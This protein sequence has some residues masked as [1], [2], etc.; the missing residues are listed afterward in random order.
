ML[1]I[2]FRGKN[3]MTLLLP[4]E[5]MTATDVAKQLNM[6]D[7]NRCLSSS[8]YVLATLSMPKFKCETEI[9]ITD[10]LTLLGLPD[11]M[12]LTKMG[13]NS[14]I[15]P[16]VKQKNVTQIDEEGA[17]VANVTGV[18][19]DSSTYLLITEKI[20]ISF[21]RPFVFFIHNYKTGTILISGIINNL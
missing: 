18:S 8:E 2:P 16:I 14:Y 1:S 4:N 5:E 17:V 9:D 6:Q 7:F 19:G 15:N 13:V 12:P 11:S 20:S 21:D 10:I 3:K